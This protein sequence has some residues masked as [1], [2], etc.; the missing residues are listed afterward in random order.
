[1]FFLLCISALFVAVSCD[2]GYCG[3]TNAYY[4][5]EGYCDIFIEC[6]ERQEFR[7]SCPDGLHFNAEAP[8]PQYP[9]GYPMDV[10]CSEKDIQQAARSTQEC[11][12]EYGFFESP[13]ATRVDCGHY[14]QCVDGVPMEMLCP[15]GLAFNPEIGR[16]D[17]PAL[18]PSC[19]AEAF[20]GY[21]CPP[22]S[23]DEYGYDI[24]ENF[25]IPGKCYSFISCHR[26]GA[27]LLTCDLGF[28]F[29]ETVNR[30]V[31]SDLVRSS[32]PCEERPSY[33]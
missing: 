9:C 29:D 10:P 26:G 22:G 3:D 8:W 23:V 24:T 12:H 13:L 7:R 33:L 2:T 28:K 18:V 15:S 5:L 11:P 20:I 14:K 1:M 32:T 31:N 27:R 4:K 19:D 25:G 6:I 17:W 21:S 16:C 30:C